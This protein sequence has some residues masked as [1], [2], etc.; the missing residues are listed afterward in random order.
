MCES[1]AACE[2]ELCDFESLSFIDDEL[3]DGPSKLFPYNFWCQV[4]SQDMPDLSAVFFGGFEMSVAFNVSVVF[5]HL[6]RIVYDRAFSPVFIVRSMTPGKD[7]F[8]VL[9]VSF[10]DQCFIHH[11]PC[12][13]VIAVS[14][15]RRI[16]LRDAPSRARTDMPWIVEIV[17][18]AN[19]SADADFG[20]ILFCWSRSMRTLR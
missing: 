5:Y 2:C 20:K 1:L 16:F 19:P 14:A 18:P 6:D 4:E 10:S 9:D 3:D 8:R 7:F 13:A 15:M 11:R 17:S 12:Q